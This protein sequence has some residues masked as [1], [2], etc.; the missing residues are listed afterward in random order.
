MKAGSP[1]VRNTFPVTLPVENESSS[2][3]SVIAQ[4]SLPTSLLTRIAV[5]SGVM[6]TPVAEP[7]AVANDG[8]KTTAAK[9]IEASLDMESPFERMRLRPRCQR[10]SSMPSCE[11]S[12]E[13]GREPFAGAG[14]GLWGSGTPLTRARSLADLA[15]QPR[16]NVD[17]GRERLVDGTLAR[18]FEQPRG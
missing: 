8:S 3:L 10:N 1:S 4:R 2:I 13:W 17:L 11:V 14:P 12:E 5:A 9:T 18:D 16:A 7:P 15:R 6:R